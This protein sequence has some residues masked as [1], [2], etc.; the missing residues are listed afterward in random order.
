MRIWVGSILFD[1][2]AYLMSSISL[3]SVDASR[4]QLV[5]ALIA[6]ISDQQ[7]VEMT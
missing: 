3:I 2:P 7:L 1:D 4:E 5:L 6:L